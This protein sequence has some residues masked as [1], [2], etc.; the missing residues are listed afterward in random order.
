MGSYL[1]CLFGHGRWDSVSLHVASSVLPLERLKA[2]NR[3]ANAQNCT[4]NAVTTATS[5]R[6][7]D[8]TSCS[9]HIVF[10]SPPQRSQCDMMQI[11]L[12]QIGE[13]AAPL[14]EVVPHTGRGQGFNSPHLSNKS[15]VAP[16][17]ATAQ[18]GSTLQQRMQ[19]HPDDI[20][21]TP[22]GAPSPAPARI[23]QHTSALLI[24][25]IGLQVERC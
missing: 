13:D 18:P 14:T 22:R 2:R 23:G 1:G 25:A 24:A 15:A 17:N 19:S 11:A 10:G 12:S 4:T 6:D 5:V 3:H 16:A 21:L 7:Q 9:K 8:F 20:C